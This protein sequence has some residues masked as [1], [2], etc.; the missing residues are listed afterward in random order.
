MALPFASDMGT[1]FPLLGCVPLP[2]M[3][4]SDPFLLSWVVDDAQRTNITRFQPFKHSLSAEI[5]GGT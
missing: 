1:F 5:T 2:Q 3:S 4:Q